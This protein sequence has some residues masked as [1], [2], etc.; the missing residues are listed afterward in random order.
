M[1]VA[2]GVFGHSTGADASLQSATHA[3]DFNIGAAVAL[4]PDHAMAGGSLSVSA[5]ANNITFCPLLIVVG[6]VE[7]PV[8]PGSAKH[9]FE[10]AAEPKIFIDRKGKDHLS[11][12]EISNGCPYL[13]A[14][15]KVYIYG[16]QGG[17]YWKMLLGGGEYSACRGFL[18]GGHA[19]H[20]VYTGTDR[21][22]DKCII[23]T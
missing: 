22:H 15:F 7:W 14:F 5:L 11:V 20:T 9:V 1:D 19:N 16:Q 4:D 17:C 3:A 8:I 12:I 21:V 18:F 6:D 2:F 10:G 13:A 23:A